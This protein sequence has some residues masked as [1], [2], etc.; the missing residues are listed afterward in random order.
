MT[1]RKLMLLFREHQKYNG[2]AKPAAT[3]DE[4]IPE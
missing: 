4:I 3:I 1:V 2:A